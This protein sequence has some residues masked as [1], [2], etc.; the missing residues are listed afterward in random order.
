VYVPFASEEELTF[1]VDGLP[2][3]TVVEL[4]IAKL[5]TSGLTCIASVLLSDKVLLTKPDEISVM[6]IVVEPGLDKA[7]VV[8]VPVPAVA[9]VIVVVL[10]AVFAPL[11][12]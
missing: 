1:T 2:A 5:L 3:Q 8:N 11:N 12:V 4:P 10:L 7:E 9:T 6:A